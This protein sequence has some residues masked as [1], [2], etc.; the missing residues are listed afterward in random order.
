MAWFSIPSYLF[1]VCF[2]LFQSLIFVHGEGL[3][4]SQS[5]SFCPK[6]FNCGNLINVTFPFTNKSQ[7]NCG[8]HSLDCAA[9]PFPRVKF[10][11]QQY[12]IRNIRGEIMWLINPLP[13]SYFLEQNCNTFYKNFSFPSSALISFMPRLHKFYRCERKSNVSLQKI[14]HYFNGFASYNNCKNFVLYYREDRN[15]TAPGGNLPAECSVIQLPFNSR[16]SGLFQ[17]LNSSISVQWVVSETCEDCHYKGGSCLIDHNNKTICSGV[18]GKS[19][20]SKVIL[21]TVFGGVILILATSLVVMYFRNHKKGCF[22]SSSSSKRDLEGGSKYFG[23]A[24]FS[25]S[26]LERA[27]NN[28]NSSK[29]LGNGGF[30][31]VYHGKLRDGREVAVKRL[32]EHNSKRMEHFINEIKIL[33]NLR[34]QNLVTLY[35]CTSRRSRELLL[36]YEYI[37][38]GTVF[39][40]LHGERAN[41][42][43]LAWPIRMNIAVE[44]AIALAYLH[45]SD[46][47]HRDV[48]TTNILLDNNFRV[49]VADFGLSRL[50]PYDATHVST[51]PQG[52]PGYVDP[53]YHECYQLTDKSDVYSFGV[54][55]VE[56]ISSMPAVDISRHRDEINLANLAVNKIQRRAFNELIDPSLGFETNTEITRMIT[57]VAELAFQCLQGK[58]D[59]RP[60][61]DDVVETLKGIQGGYEFKEDAINDETNK[62]NTTLES[63]DVVLLKR[64][65][66]F[67][68]SPT[69]VTDKWTSCS[70]ATSNSR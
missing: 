61:M 42:V 36:V 3:S 40:H 39:D 6:Q 70:T 11:E 29:E 69:S 14:G 18:A 53:E 50:L 54:V 55:L 24:V 32:Y 45:A 9:R 43:P 5:Q 49:K 56:L 2:V 35:G 65:S 64:I 63:E 21:A 59:L 30:G 46:I 31:A 37:P 8:L 19:I 4:Q 58:K 51:A 66:R 68:T 47:I 12:D 38:N 13:Q 20:K 34:H 48:K 25:Y 52:T 1:W 62:N 28:F 60:T 33:T 7:P 57:S 23:V 15:D 22:G 26:E 67:P 41:G 16:A 17:K 44:T 27:T 10:G